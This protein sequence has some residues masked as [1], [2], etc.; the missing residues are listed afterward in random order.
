MSSHPAP[1][2]IQADS[3]LD[4]STTALPG[5]VIDWVESLPWHAALAAI[6]LLL[7]PTGTVVKGRWILPNGTMVQVEKIRTSVPV[8]NS[9]WKSLIDSLER[10][11]DS[12]PHEGSCAAVGPE[13]V[14]ITS[15]GD[16]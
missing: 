15:L 5:H 4:D 16:A 11:R 9:A 2:D 12:I 1:A 13:T 14:A 10:L 6:I 7:D 3:G 8:S